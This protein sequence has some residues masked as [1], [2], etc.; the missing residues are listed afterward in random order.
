MEAM[1]EPQT[2]SAVRDRV[3]TLHVKALLTA[4][5]VMGAT[6]AASS[7]GHA[8]PAKETPLV[9]CMVQKASLQS[10][11]AVANAAQE[12]VYCPP[13]QLYPGE[14][15]KCSTAENYRLLVKR[16]VFEL[17]KECSREFPSR[18]A[19]PDIEESFMESLG[20]DD[21]VKVMI[22]KRKDAYE[23]S[24]GDFERA[25]PVKDAKSPLDK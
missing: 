16:V 20:K 1:Q 19:L 2:I 25:H 17:A 13:S 22:E 23:K 18:A 21:T 10:K 8:E 4:T 24:K 7:G 6:L 14:S 3:K 12:S 9:S 11:E 15:V 5:V